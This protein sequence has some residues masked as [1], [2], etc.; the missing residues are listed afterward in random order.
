MRTPTQAEIETAI[1]D[2]HW[3]QNFHGF[4]ICSG[5]CCPCSVTIDHGNCDTL[6]R[7]FTEKAAE[8]ADSEDEG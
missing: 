7:L 6:K 5:M 1:R 3:R 4:A 8:S 2:C